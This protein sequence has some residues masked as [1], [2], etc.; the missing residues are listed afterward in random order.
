MAIDEL[1]AVVTPPRYPI[2]I[3]DANSWLAAESHLRTRLPVD[4]Y[5]YAH[6]YGSGRIGDLIVA[7]PFSENYLDFIRFHCT[8]LEDYQTAMSGGPVTAGL[9]EPYPIHPKRPGLLPWGVDAD[10]RIGWW[11]TEGVPDQWPIL[12]SFRGDEFQRF[13]L[14]MTSFL[15]QLLSPRFTLVSWWNSLGKPVFIP[16]QLRI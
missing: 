6:K 5:A 14:R 3:G 13:D 7:N 11:L 1:M 12:V 15:A 8:R 4:Y 10:D 9:P 2:K 16:E